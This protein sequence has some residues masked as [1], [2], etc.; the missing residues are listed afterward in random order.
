[1]EHAMK[2][3]KAESRSCDKRRATR[4]NVWSRGFALFLGGF[5][6]LNLFGS[7]R[8]AWFDAN[9]WWIDLRWLPQG[10]AQAGLFISAV[11]LVAFAFRPPASPAR[12]WLT[13]ACGGSLGL[14]AALN[15]LR[16][17]ALWLRGTVRS[18]FPLPVSLLIAVA[19]GVVVV[20]ALRTTALPVPRPPL[21]LFPAASTG[22]GIRRPEGGSASFTILYVFVVALGCAVSFP[23]AQMFCFGK[24]D[25]RRPADAV[26]VLGARAYA[27]GRPSDAL[28]D[29]VRTA[30]RLYRDGLARKLVF[31]GGPGDGAVHEPECMRRMAIQLGVKPED[32]LA[33]PDGLNTGE[34]VRNTGRILAQLHATR[35]LAVSHFYH[36]PRIKLAYQAAGREVYTV[37]AKESYILR[38][39]PY[40]MA[41]EVAALW[42]YY[43]RAILG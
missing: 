32:I 43:C 3:T 17:Y 11:C 34:T 20:A 25:Y 40:N 30:C 5:T 24:T 19:L 12:R 8:R 4:Q 18:G 22:P 26:V 16:F 21:L 41:R 14:V 36:L 1:M 35:V 33:D 7:F 9:L 6:L 31:S 13:A 10:V 15:A 39:M 42:E 27:D 37:P 29:R 28:A 2:T 38:Q 23:L